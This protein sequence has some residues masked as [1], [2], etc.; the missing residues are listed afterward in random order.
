MPIESD[1]VTQLEADSDVTDTV[2]TRIYPLK[3]PQNPT[4]P[5]ITYE[6]TDGYPI[7][8]HSVYSG[9]N[10]SMI[11]VICWASTYA[12]AKT[13]ASYV[14]VALRGGA[15][16]SAQHCWLEYNGDGDWDEVQRVFTVEMEFS[17][18]HS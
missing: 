11:R 13:L 2:S 12:E 4:Y 7:K 17:I 8:S 14:F 5:A 3:L 9:L 1:L 15:W 10:A 16:G 18:Y 6:H